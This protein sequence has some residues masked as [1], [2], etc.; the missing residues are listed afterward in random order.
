M[1]PPWAVTVTAFPVM[2]EFP[3]LFG[4]PPP[5]NV[6]GLPA[7]TVYGTFGAVTANDGSQAYSPAA[8]PYDPPLPLMPKTVPVWPPVAA[9]YDSALTVVTPAGMVKFLE[10]GVVLLWTTT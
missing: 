2:V 10:P 8:P 4:V 7:P 6:P 1:V 9:P 3:A 5:G